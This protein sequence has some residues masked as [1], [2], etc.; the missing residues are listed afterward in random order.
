M[1]KLSLVMAFI[2]AFSLFA[3]PVS[4][5]NMIYMTTADS[6]YYEEGNWQTTTHSLIKGYNGAPSRYL[7]G[8]PL[9]PFMSE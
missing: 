8:A 1:K 7:S 2:M 6:N 9:Y 3:L 4:A 5:E